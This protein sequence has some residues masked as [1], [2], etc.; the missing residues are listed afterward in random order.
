MSERATA[1]SG[2][3][4]LVN[5]RKKDKTWGIKAAGTSQPDVIC[6]KTHGR[7]FTYARNNPPSKPPTTATVRINGLL[8]AYVTATIATG[9]SSAE[10]KETHR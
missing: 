9:S 6:G 4:V 5:G 2:I 7:F 3:R 10:N 8:T 1:L